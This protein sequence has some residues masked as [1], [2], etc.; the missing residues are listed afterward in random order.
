MLLPAGETIEQQGTSN[1][2]G[3]GS[4]ATV[5]VEIMHNLLTTSKT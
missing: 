3:S 2:A 4:E 1:Q 5:L